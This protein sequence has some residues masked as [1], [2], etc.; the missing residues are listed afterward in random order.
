VGLDETGDEYHGAENSRD[1]IVTYIG[2]QIG[3][4]TASW[5]EILRPSPNA[6]STSRADSN[7]DPNAAGGYLSA[8]SAGSVSQQDST[9]KG[10]SSARTCDHFCPELNACISADLWCDG[11]VHCPSG[12]DETRSTCFQ[13]PLLWL[14]A[15][16][17]VAL[18]VVLSCFS[19]CLVVH[20][21]RSKASA[22]RRENAVAQVRGPSVRN[23]IDYNSVAKRERKEEREKGKERKRE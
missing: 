22:T 12:V 3:V 19:V 2:H 1:L 11:V 6:P 23:K 9:D 5:M 17:G 7:Y 14:L 21:Y 18:T 15:G 13:M 20:K 10:S 8:T 16:I 4:Y